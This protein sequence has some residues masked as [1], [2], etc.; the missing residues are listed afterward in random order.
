MITIKIGDLLNAN[1]EII[2]HQVNCFGGVAGLAAQIFDKWPEAGKFYDNI[3][4]ISGFF[5]ENHIG[6]RKDNL[7]GAMFIGPF[8]EGGPTIANIFGQYYAGADYRPD[9]LRKGLEEVAA[10]ARERNLSVALPYGISCGICGGD[11]TEVREIINE[12]MEGVNCVLY[13]REGD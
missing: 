12:T 8:G 1:E 11:W 6:S 4:A 9:A 13:K 10:F 2:G 3:T 7:G 5:E